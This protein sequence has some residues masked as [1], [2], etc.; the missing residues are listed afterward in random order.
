MSRQTIRNGLFAFFGGTSGDIC[1]V[2]NVSG[3]TSVY[4]AF[5]KDWPEQDMPLMAF[6][7]PDGKEKR[8]ALQTK[9]ITYQVRIFL[10]H[11]GVDTDSQTAEENFEVVL[12]SVLAKIRSDKTMGGSVFKWGEV[13]QSTIDI[14]RD[15]EQ[16][17]LTA[18]I[19]AETVE[20]LNG[21]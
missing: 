16:V 3:I 8:V 17:V 2:P 11:F 19:E 20:R 12:D 6:T 15:E 9:E 18:A 7:I 4:K 21:V 1:R 13:M 14:E 10:I 5:P